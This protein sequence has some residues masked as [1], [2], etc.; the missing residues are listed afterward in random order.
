MAAFSDLRTRLAAER[1]SILTELATGD[2]LPPGLLCRLADVHFALQALDHC[3]TDDASRGARRVLVR[4]VADAPLE[5]VL[6]DGDAA[7]VRADLQ[8]LHAL[9]LAADLVEGARR[10]LADAVGR[11]A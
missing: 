7:P 1:N 8:P 4:D 2:A 3:V 9:A 10:R 11:S 5:L 6:Y